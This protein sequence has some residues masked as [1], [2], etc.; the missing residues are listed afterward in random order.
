MKSGQAKD[1]INRLTSLISKGLLNTGFVV[2]PKKFLPETL[3]VSPV[4]KTILLA[5][6]SDISLGRR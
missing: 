6:S 5:K 3:E 4:M 1:S 2:A